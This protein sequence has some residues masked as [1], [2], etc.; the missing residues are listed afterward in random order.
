MEA[1]KVGFRKWLLAMH[2]IHVHRKGIASHQ[3]ARELGVTQKTAWF[4]VHR[5]REGLGDGG[6]MLSGD[7]EID[8][9]YLGGK[10]ADKPVEKRSGARYAVGKQADRASASAW[11]ASKWVG[12]SACVG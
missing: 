6:D 2:L 5:I 12:W 1:S 9:S 8:E 3:L 11:A 10:E 4:M 7:V